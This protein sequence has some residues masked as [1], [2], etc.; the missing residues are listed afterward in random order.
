MNESQAGFYRIRLVQQRTP[1]G[2]MWTAEHPG[3]LGCHVVRT[4]AQQAVDDLA[5]V[6][7]DWIERARAAG[8]DVP[9]PEPNLYYELIL[10]PD[11]SPEDAVE[12]RRAVEVTAGGIHTEFGPTLAFA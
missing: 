8:E 5:V 6:R 12:A 3:L 4:G 2:E 7:T 9:P 1:Q 10:A 11:H